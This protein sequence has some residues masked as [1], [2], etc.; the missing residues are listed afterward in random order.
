MLAVKLLGK[1]EFLAKNHPFIE[2]H[3]VSSSELFPD[4]TSKVI[5]LLAES[6]EGHFEIFVAIEGILDSCFDLVLFFEEVWTSGLIIL[7]NFLP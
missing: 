5:G 3:L 1:I 4:K 7:D 2:I 6:F